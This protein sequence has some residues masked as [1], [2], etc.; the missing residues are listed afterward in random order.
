MKLINNIKDQLFK[1][2][3]NRMEDDGIRLQKE[4]KE[5]RAITTSSLNLNN[6]INYFENGWKINL[7]PPISVC[8]ENADVHRMVVVDNFL[9]KNPQ[10]SDKIK[11]R[12]A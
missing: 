12:K 2:I 6:F 5:K 7:V 1:H 9:N 8:N 10:Y 4:A 11:I 3:S